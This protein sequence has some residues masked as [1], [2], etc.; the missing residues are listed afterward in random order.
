MDVFGKIG[1]E[2]KLLVPFDQMKDE[3][4]SPAVQHCPIILTPG[5]S[6]SGEKIS[7]FSGSHVW[8]MGRSFRKRW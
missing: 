7:R 5:T 2:V 4:M 3:P 1:S 8:L 6:H